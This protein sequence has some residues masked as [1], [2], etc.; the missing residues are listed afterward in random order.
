M[1][2]NRK[3]YRLGLCASCSHLRSYIGGALAFSCVKDGILGDKKCKKY[4]EFEFVPY[5]T[6]EKIV[7]GEWQDFNDNWQDFKGEDV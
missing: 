2:K 6:F 3:H 4:E 7:E 5:E 1:S